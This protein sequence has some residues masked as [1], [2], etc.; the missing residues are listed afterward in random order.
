MTSSFR[1]SGRLPFSRLRAS[2]WAYIAGSISPLRSVEVTF[3]FQHGAHPGRRAGV[4]A[5]DERPGHPALA[6]NVVQQ[7]SQEEPPGLAR[8]LQVLAPDV[9]DEFLSERSKPPVLL[10]ERLQRLA[11][12]GRRLPEDGEQEVLLIEQM[13]R[14][15]VRELLDRQGRRVL[16][17][18]KECPVSVVPQVFDQPGQFAEE[19]A[20]I[21]I[22]LQP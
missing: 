2:V 5:L 16:R 3:R 21:L 7:R 20:I 8:R 11:G 19:R 6:R 15:E 17:L 18:E 9:L 4:E 10:L 22:V 13:A 12:P 14:E 1:F